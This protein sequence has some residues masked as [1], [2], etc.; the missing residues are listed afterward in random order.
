MHLYNKLWA[1][2]VLDVCLV[3]CNFARMG[4]HQKLK[5]SLYE[6]LIIKIESDF[7]T[8]SSHSLNDYKLFPLSV[9]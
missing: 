1:L 5:A 2:S 6:K 7:D 9:F 8:Q 3:C 4:F